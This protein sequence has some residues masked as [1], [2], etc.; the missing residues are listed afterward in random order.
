MSE[1]TGVRQTLPPTRERPGR[2]I[3]E[4]LSLRLPGLRR[5][6]QAFV[7]RRPPQ[8]LLRR[9]L[10]AWSTVR[11]FES[12]N[13][14]DFELNKIVY[15]EDAEL[16]FIGGSP[17]I[18]SSSYKGREAVFRAYQEWLE[19]WENLRRRPREVIDLGDKFVYLIEESGR[20]S[21]SGIE[22]SQRIANIY[23]MRDGLIAKHE[24]FT[25]DWNEALEYAGI[26]P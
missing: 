3:D 5:S 21:G 24:E 20:G 1:I 15:D 17:G 11:G 16:V 7:L 26:K 9:R 13:R 10:V 6:I 12:L 25:G 22:V 4:W 8:S 14:R 2:G 19:P 23:T 18:G